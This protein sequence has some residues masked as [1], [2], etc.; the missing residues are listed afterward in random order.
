MKLAGLILIVAWIAFAAW[1]GS[2]T[3]EQVET[4]PGNMGFKDEPP[5][6]YE[7]RA[8]PDCNVKLH[9]PK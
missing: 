2:T 4:M 1:L 9:M 8:D 6:A 3:S 7:G 5:A